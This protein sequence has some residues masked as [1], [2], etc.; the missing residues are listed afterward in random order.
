VPPDFADFAEAPEPEAQVYSAI[1]VAPSFTG[2]TAVPYTKWYNVHERHS[3]NEFKQEGVI[4]LIIAVILSVHLWGTKA[5]RSK[6]KLWI[7]ATAPV[8]QKEFSLVGFGK[9]PLTIEDAQ[10]EGLARALVDNPEIQL[11]KETSL[12]EFKTYATGRTNVA[13]VDANIV[14]FK[15]YNPFIMLIDYAMGFVFDSIPVP[16]EL[17]RVRIFL[18]YQLLRKFNFDKQLIR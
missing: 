16:T 1:P 4:L 15:R 8:L 17:M 10:G 2:L 6:A 18:L 11:L 14:L 7:S 13:F 3:I 9:K 5:N 12:S